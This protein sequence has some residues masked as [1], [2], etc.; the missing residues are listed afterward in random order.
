MHSSVTIHIDLHMPTY[1]SHARVLYGT[2]CDANH[3]VLHDRCVHTQCFHQNNEKQ[4]FRFVFFLKSVPVSSLHASGQHAAEYV[5]YR[6]IRQCYNERQGEILCP[7]A[8]SPRTA[9]AT[10]HYVPLSDASS[11]ASTYESIA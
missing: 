3:V 11:I 2:K 10:K 9:L 1:S 7:L 4:A 6:S 5:F 8:G